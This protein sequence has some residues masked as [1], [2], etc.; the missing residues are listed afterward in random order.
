MLGIGLKNAILLILIILILH[1]LIKNMMLEKS[2]A[3]VPP[4]SETAVVVSPQFGSN[5]APVK[6]DGAKEQ[7]ELYKYVMGDGDGDESLEKFFPQGAPEVADTKYDVACDAKLA[8]LPMAPK[9]STQNSSHDNG[10][11]FTVQDYKHNETSFSSG[12]LGDLSGYDE[13]GGVYEAYKK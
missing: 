10:H 11:F 4:P 2:G 7:S 1:F 12:K 9:A 6:H 5:E 8:E 3:I 13:Y